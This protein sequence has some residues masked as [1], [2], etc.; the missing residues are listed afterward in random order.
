MF[1]ITKIKG[2]LLA[3][4]RNWMYVIL[5]VLTSTLGAGSCARFSDREIEVGMLSSCPPVRTGTMEFK[6]RSGSKTAL[7]TQAVFLPME[8]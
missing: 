7:K 4:A 6:P 3:C 2:F 5:S 1:E 8:I